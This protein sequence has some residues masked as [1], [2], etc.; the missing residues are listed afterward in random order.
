MENS[1]PDAAAYYE[2]EG[3]EEG[4]L[5]ELEEGEILEY[6][7]LIILADAKEIKS[8]KAHVDRRKKSAAN[9]IMDSSGRAVRGRAARQHRALRIKKDISL[10]LH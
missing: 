9:V 2:R 1:N 8:R 5:F 10:F 6:E 7:N 4:E 3:G